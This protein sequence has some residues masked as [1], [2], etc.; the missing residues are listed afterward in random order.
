MRGLLLS[1]VG[2]LIYAAGVRDAI[3]VTKRGL[4]GDG[5]RKNNRVDNRSKAASL[6]ENQVSA[7]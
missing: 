7:N 6:P 5:I 2:Q 4:T 3:P 1:V